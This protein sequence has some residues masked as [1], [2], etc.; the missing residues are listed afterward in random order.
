[1][2][3]VLQKMLC[4]MPRRRQQAKPWSQP[5]YLQDHCLPL[6]PN[7]D[8]RLC[9]LGIKFLSLNVCLPLMFRDSSV[10][11]TPFTQA[12]PKH[13]CLPALRISSAAHL[14][15]HPRHQEHHLLAW[16]AMFGESQKVGLIPGPCSLPSTLKR[17]LSPPSRSSIF[18]SS[19]Q[20]RDERCVLKSVH[21]GPVNIQAQ[22]DRLPL[23]RTALLINHASGKWVVC[24]WG[25][26]CHD[27][28]PMK[29][30]ECEW[31]KRK[32]FTFHVCCRRAKTRFYLKTTPL[33]WRLKA[34]IWA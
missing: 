11:P 22:A 12:W 3:S 4:W 2:G 13:L 31:K 8:Q 20:P 21:V 17:I 25:P 18:A 6:F 26:L 7:F 33:S 1:M 10:W 29:M 16:A 27:W 15:W 14:S 24:T 19:R 5:H 23:G 30:S 32:Q 34:S 9:W 28:A